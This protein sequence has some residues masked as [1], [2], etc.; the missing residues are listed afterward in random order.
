MTVG[1][2]YHAH[3]PLF[4]GD[5]LQSPRTFYVVVVARKVKTRDG[6]PKW[7][8]ACDKRFDADRATERALELSPD[9]PPR[10]FTLRWFARGRRRR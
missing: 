3:G 4:A 9:R 2:T 10:F 7:A 6:K 8:L 1:I 5:I